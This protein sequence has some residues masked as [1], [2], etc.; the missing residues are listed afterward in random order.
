M[1]HSITTYIVG[2]GKQHPFSGMLPMLSL[3]KMFGY[4]S[5]GEVSD[6]LHLE[7]CSLPGCAMP[8]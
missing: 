8:Y 1:R 2:E 7:L 5:L 4:C 3:R 6:L